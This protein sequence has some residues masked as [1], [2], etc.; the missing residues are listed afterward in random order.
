MR[1]D[2]AQ[3]LA[4]AKIRELR[5]NDAD[6]VVALAQ[7]SPESANWSK[8]SYLQLA[9]ASASLALVA[10]LNGAIC[11]F[12]VGRRTADQAEV[13]NLVVKYQHRRQGIA[14][15]L[16]S[17]ALREF[18]LQGANSVFLEVRESNAPAIA[19]YERQGFSKTGKRKDYYRD[20]A[21]AALTMQK[22]LTG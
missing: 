3:Q 4:A 7:A 22:K 9:V 14:S 18:A 6:A 5:A 13:F 10:E 17:A 19:F 11:A 2:R 16:M 1:V 12:L 15:A 21:E 20:P 8:E